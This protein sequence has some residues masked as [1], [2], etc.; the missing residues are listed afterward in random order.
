MMLVFV[1][2]DVGGAC[3]WYVGTSSVGS[4]VGAVDGR[5]IGDYVCDGVGGAVGLLG[6]AVLVLVVGDD[7][8][9]DV[10]GAVGRL[11]R[12]VLFYVL[13]MELLSAMMLVMLL[14]VLLVCWDEK[15]W[16]CRRCC[17]WKNVR[18]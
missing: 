2:V 4:V 17:R 14:E 16:F 15:C 13:S 12:A 10:G 7:V 6:R 5:T 9:V 8:S 1:S 18:R 3:C 11:G